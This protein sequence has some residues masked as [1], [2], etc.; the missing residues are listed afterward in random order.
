MTLAI[1]FAIFLFLILILADWMQFGRVTTATS[2]YGCVAGRREERVAGLSDGALM[3]RFDAQGWLYLPHGVARL[4]REDRL[5]LLRPRYR[6]FSQF[7]SA[8]PMKS[9][10]QWRADQDGAVITSIKRMPWSS[11]LLTALWFVVVGL[12]SLAFL[13]SYLWNG[14]LSSLG[15]LVM[16]LGVT[17]LGVIVLAFGAAT[18]VAAYR[19]EDQRL[20]T[21][22]QEWKETVTASP[23]T[24]PATPGARPAIP[25]SVR[26]WPS[27]R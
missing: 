10:L 7:R 2:H 4:F 16:G 25:S 8:W 20:A 9:A 21:V 5:I 6:T 1:F 19:L 12:G 3:A 26:S 14:G 13:G 17:A 11:A 22:Y 23:E 18:V 27:P 24:L 15:G